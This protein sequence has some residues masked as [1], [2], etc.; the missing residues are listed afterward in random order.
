MST[1]GIIICDVQTMMTTTEPEPS[2][3]KEDVKSG[4]G[5]EDAPETE[6][7]PQTQ[8]HLSLFQTLSRVQS[9]HGIPLLDYAQYHEYC[10]KRLHRIRHHKDVRNQLVN[11]T[12]Y[13]K[14]AATSA[15]GAKAGSG[16]GDATAA[17]ASSKKSRS[18]SSAGGRHA[19]CAQPVLPENGVI[20]HEY[21]LWNLVFQAERA[22]SMAC[23]MQGNDSATS[24]GPNSSNNNSTFGKKQKAPSKSH[25]ISRL[26]KAVHWASL[27][28]SA[29]SNGT[30]VTPTTQ[31]E[32]Q[33]YL[34]WMKGNQQLQKQDYVGAFRSFT[35]SR[36]LLLELASTKDGSGEATTDAE[37]VARQDMW[38]NRANDLLLPLIRYCQYEAKDDDLVQPEES[39]SSETKAK[40]KKESHGISVEFRNQTIVLD[41]YAQLAVLYLKLEKHLVGSALEK[42]ENE[43]EVTSSPLSE[44]EFLQCLSDLDD[45]LR[46]SVQELQRYQ[47]LPDGPAVHAKRRELS[48]LKAFFQYHKLSLQRQ[49]QEDRLEQQESNV[50]VADAA[51]MLHVY[52]ALLKNVQAMADLNR[53]DENDSAE[54]PDAKYNPEDDPLWLE[55]QT[56]VVRI[57]ALRC[58]QL[59]RL[60][61]SPQWLTGT[62]TEQVLALLHQCRRLERRAQEE[63]AACEFAN[64]ADV[65]KYQKQLEMLHVHVLAM[66]ARV[67]AVRFLEQGEADTASSKATNRPLWLRLRDLDAGVV[68]ADQDPSPI[69]MPIPCKPVFYD[70]A[71]EHVTDSMSSMNVLDDYIARSEPQKTKSGSGLFG[72]FS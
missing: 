47:A 59:A 33:S 72:W 71:W 13:R 4:E 48:S 17:A 26:N 19:F 20:S 50:F 6:S 14:Q 32:I 2:G 10:T 16:G 67:S 49:H 30:C 8:F 23:S 38:T 44:T 22:W 70:V 42:D 41:S 29:T 39:A 9:E 69:L 21:V 36:T 40:A 12:K 52:E 18:R 66:I 28:E 65:E 54:N 53:Q 58:F 3:S 64:P 34:Q 63:V 5:N 45:A 35:S 24:S 25:I 15:A 60:Y 43:N 68:L 51:E 55:A 57:R 31:R 11:S 7:A 61:E 56:H 46:L 1:I 27:L 62:T 37:Q